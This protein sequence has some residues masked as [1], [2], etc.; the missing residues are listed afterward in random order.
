VR[1][2][3]H[4]DEIPLYVYIGADPTEEEHKMAAGILKWG[5][6]G[7]EGDQPLK[8]ITIKDM[9]TDHIHAVLENVRAIQPA[10]RLCMVNELKY[11]KSSA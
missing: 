11:R 6:Y 4:G 9:E 5:T 8:F 3:A 7:K 10:L 2:S 1:S